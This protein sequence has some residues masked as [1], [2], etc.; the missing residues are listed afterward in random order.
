MRQ[1]LPVISEEAESLKQRLQRAH[2]G[3]QKPRL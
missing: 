2:D 1:A 3:R